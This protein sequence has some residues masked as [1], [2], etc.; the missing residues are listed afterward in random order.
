MAAPRRKACFA[1]DV[2]SGPFYVKVTALSLQSLPP[3]MAAKKNLHTSLFV[4]YIAL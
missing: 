4:S 2:R 3:A 1:L